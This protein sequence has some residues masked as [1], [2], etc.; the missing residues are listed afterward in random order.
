[1]LFEDTYLTIAKPAEGLFRDRGS[2]FLAFAYP[3]NNDAELKNII[4][5]LKAEHPK[6]NHHCWA[7][8]LGADRSVF[9]LNDDGEPSGTAGRPILN[10][11]LSHNITN[12][13]L[14]V[15]RYFG[16]TL[17]GVPGLINAYKC[18]AEDALKN[19]EVIEKTVNDIYTIAF[20]YLQ[21]NEVMKI[22][23]DEG[24]QIINQNFDNECVI[25]VSIRQTRVN[26]ALFKVNKITPV[27]VS[28]NYTV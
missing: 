17:L 7:L 15:T 8:R 25:Q 26:G 2:K 23:K 4:A 27:K 9:R 28:Y 6:A 12:I 10:T 22:I 19:A 21:M 13:L 5:K 3:V 1:M 11:L 20:H 18:A 24:L 14:V 16:G